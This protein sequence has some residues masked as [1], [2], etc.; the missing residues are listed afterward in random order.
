MAK[1]EQLSHGRPREGEALGT[2]AQMYGIR[3]YNYAL[4]DMVSGAACDGSHDSEMERRIGYAIQDA[5][6]RGF[7]RGAETLEMKLGA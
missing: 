3:V 1:D 7:R 6:E 5:Y 4:I 2:W